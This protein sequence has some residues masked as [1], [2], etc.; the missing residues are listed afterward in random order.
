MLTAL[1][2]TGYVVGTTSRGEVAITSDDQPP[3]P[4][5]PTL[6]IA[7]ASVAEGHAGIRTLVFTLTLSARQ[8]VPVSVRWTTADGTA[9]AGRDYKSESGRVIFSPGQTSRTI[10]VRVIGDRAFEAD[11]TFKVRLVEPKQA[12]LAAAFATG[13]ITNDDPQSASGGVRRS[14]AKSSSRELRSWHSRSGAG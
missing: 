5:L 10:A 4:T 2:G 9:T 3:A 12:T 11:E 14:G 13:T 6:S 8:N 1:S 7:N